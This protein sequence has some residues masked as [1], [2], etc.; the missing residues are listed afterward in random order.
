MKTLSAFI[1][2]AIAL[3]TYAAAPSVSSRHGPRNGID[4]VRRWNEIA[5]NASGLDHTPPAPGEVRVF[6]EQLGPGRASRALAIVHIAMFDAVNAVVGEYES[7]TG[8]RAPNGPLSMEAAI[9]QAAHDTL[10]ALFPAQTASFDAWLAEDLAEIKN[11]NARAN[12]INL[13]KRAAIAILTLKANDGSEI[14]EPLMGI[15]HI[16]SDLAGHW[17]QDPISLIPL[18]LGAK[19]GKCIPFVAE[20]NSQFRVPP[21]PAMTSPEYAAAFNEVKRLG[22]DGVVTPTERTPE[23]TFIGIF[24]AY[25]GTPSLCAPPK[26]YNQIALQIADQMG[27]S[28][29]E[30][31]RL[32]ALINVAMADAGTAAWE[33]KY[34]HDI[35]RPVT[36]IRES[37]LGTGPTGSGDGNDAT[38]GDPTFSPLGAPASNLTGPNFTPPFP[39][40]PSGHATFGGA[41]FQ[42]LRRFYGTDNIPFTFVSDEFN[43]VTRANDG[44]VRPLIPRSFST[45]SQ[46]EEE[47][48]QS[49]IYLGIHWKFDKTAGIAQGR[50]VAD[51]VFDHSFAPLHRKGR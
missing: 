34:Y 28:D 37:D 41:I 32:L 2:L 51:Y 45:L 39:A 3:S 20:S 12:G 16:P 11:E 22:G 10:A 25:D 9:S 18:A 44:S 8:L 19:W 31:A 4:A 36:G 48:G 5:I 47:N 46:A 15:G 30:V 6:R 33:S 27:S 43:G 17:R 13:G 26:L 35:W 38:V 23:Q 24:W 42:I 29:I 49:R 50:Q 1:V 40:Y 14:P 21:P 7:Y